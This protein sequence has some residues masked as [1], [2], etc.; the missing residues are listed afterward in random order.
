MAAYCSVFKTLAALSRRLML[1]KKENEYQ[2]DAVIWLISS[3]CFLLSFN[4]IILKQLNKLIY[5][6][7]AFWYNQAKVTV[8]L[9]YGKYIFACTLQKIMTAGTSWKLQNIRIQ[10]TKMAFPAYPNNFIR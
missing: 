3:T 1:K 5:Q 7:F 6:A 4:V 10:S 8:K 9:L 2:E